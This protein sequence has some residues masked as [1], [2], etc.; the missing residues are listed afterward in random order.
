MKFGT[1]ISLKNLL[2]CGLIL[3][4]V[5]I[6]FFS[7][8]STLNVNAQEGEFQSLRKQVNL[9]DRD[10]NN[11]FYAP[12]Y[13][14]P[15]SKDPCNEDMIDLVQPPEDWEIGFQFVGDEGITCQWIY[16]H[17]NTIIAIDSWKKFDRSL[18]YRD[19][20]IEEDKTTLRAWDSYN[21]GRYTCVKQRY[22]IDFDVEECY[23]EAGEIVSIDP[24]DTSLSPLPPMLYWFFYR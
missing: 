3:L 6:I 19:F 21:L 24:L 22:Y 12:F 9:I 14:S 18:A 5:P 17:H 4:F 1:R 11:N 16:Y 2:I 13:L 23:T 7:I 20:F 8:I 10:I 15:S